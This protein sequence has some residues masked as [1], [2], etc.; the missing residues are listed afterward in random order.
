MQIH[1]LHLKGKRKPNLIPACVACHAVLHMGHSLGLGV[2]EI[3]E[4]RISQRE[5]VRRTR[6]GIRKRKSLKEVKSSLPISRGH[7]PPQS[8]EWAAQ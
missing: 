1:R 8:L 6:E 5:I 2:L 4:S 7:L 3:W